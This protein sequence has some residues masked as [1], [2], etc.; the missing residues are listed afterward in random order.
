[1][2]T[3]QKFKHEFCFVY[4][5]I[6]FYS[7][8]VLLFLAKDVRHSLYPAIYALKVIRVGGADFDAI[9]SYLQCGSWGCWTW[10]ML[11]GNWTTGLNTKWDLQ[12]TVSFCTDCLYC[13][14]MKSIQWLLLLPTSWSLQWLPLLPTSVSLCSDYLYYPLHEVSAVTAFITYFMTSLQ[15]LPLLPNL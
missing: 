10:C 6:C 8:G 9:I 4:Y 12:S 1:M 14:F 15:W 5:D 13:L 11:C 7:T 2:L 3:L